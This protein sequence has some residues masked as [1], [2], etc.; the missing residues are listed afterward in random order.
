MADT[1]ARPPAAWIVA[2][3]LP[4]SACLF[5]PDESDDV[6]VTIDAPSALVVQGQTLVLRAHAWRGAGGTIELPGVAFEW[7]SGDPGTAQVTGRPDGTALAA[8]IG[9]GPVEIRALARGYADAT[10]GSL[11]L[12]VTGAVEVDSVRPAT[13]RYGE[14]LTVFGAGMGRVTRASLGGAELIMDGS[15]LVEDAS[16]AGQVRFWVPYPAVSD[17]LLAVAREGFSTPAPDSTTIL[18]LDLYDR[19]NGAP[20]VIDLNGP[21]TR[22]TDTLYHNPALALMG[23]G[24]VDGLRFVRNDTTRPLTIVVSTTPPVVTFFEPVLYPN[25]ELP[26]TPPDVQFGGPAWMA[27]VASQ[28]CRGQRRTL[29]KPY[30]RTASVSVVRAFM[31]SPAKDLLLGVYGD[32]P[33]RYAVTVIDGY[34]TADPRIGPDRFEEN[35]TCA[36]ADE[37]SLDPATRIELPAPFGDTLTIDN[38]YEVD[39][40]PFKVPGDFFL[41]P[42]VVVTVRT[43]SRPFGASDS[44]DLGVIV[45]GDFGDLVFAESHAAGSTERLTFEVRAGIYYVIVTDDVG[46]PTRYSLCL[47]LGSDCALPAAIRGPPSAEAPARSAA[48]PKRRLGP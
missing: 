46:V 24:G 39:W 47:A 16:G 44:S 36:L 48:G 6:V 41:D 45:T 34:V 32:P 29:I 43:S 27:G 33:G 42:P 10:A 23:P 9:I 35:D 5:P 12:R 2:A 1:I 22:G 14:Q 8:G 20:P 18:P 7:V 4:L 30:R 3:A 28:Y 13:I 19:E 25:L 37:R 15:S 38:P 11:L 40:I 26:G 31:Q 17:R 21:P